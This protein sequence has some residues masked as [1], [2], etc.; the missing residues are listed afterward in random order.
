MN[1][2][3]EL[4]ANLKRIMAA[5]NK[6]DARLAVCQEM[7]TT[8]LG[9]CTLENLQ[10]ILGTALPSRLLAAQ[11]VAICEGLLAVLDLSEADEEAFLARTKLSLDQFAQ[12]L[13]DQIVERDKPK[14]VT[15]GG[16]IAGP[17]VSGG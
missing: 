8:N 17:V 13:E 4:S 9:G 14:I 16:G 7:Q 6:L 1:L 10:R 2:S 15:T 11:S 12:D 5:G 3:A